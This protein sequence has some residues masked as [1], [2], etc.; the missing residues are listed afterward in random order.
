[1]NATEQKALLAILHDGDLLAAIDYVEGACKPSKPE[2][3]P[4]PKPL[5]LIHI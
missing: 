5:S 3:A 1:M 4:A 2:A